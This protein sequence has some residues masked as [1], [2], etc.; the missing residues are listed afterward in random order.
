MLYISIDPSITSTAVT[1]MS[2]DKKFIKSYFFTEKKKFTHIPY[3]HF[4][5]LVC[6]GSWRAMGN[7][8]YRNYL[9]NAIIDVISDHIHDFDYRLVIEGYSYSSKGLTFSIGEFVGLLKHKIAITRGWQYTEVPPATVKKFIL[10]G[11]AGKT[12]LMYTFLTKQIHEIHAVNPEWCDELRK[13]IGD[14]KFKFNLQKVDS[15]L[16]DILDSVYIGLW[17]MNEDKYADQL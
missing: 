5:S 6:P 11:N 4:Q 2:S 7:D 8:F 17:R 13:F 9:T 16:S 14:E 10:K 1:V 12:D 15:P 3:D